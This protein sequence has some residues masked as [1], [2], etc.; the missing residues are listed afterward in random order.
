MYVTHKTVWT[1]FP[2]CSLRVHVCFG[3]LVWTTHEAVV[4]RHIENYS[5]IPYRMFLLT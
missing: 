1:Q 2:C 5:Y 3:W 4:K